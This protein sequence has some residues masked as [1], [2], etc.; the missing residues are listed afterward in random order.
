MSNGYKHENAFLYIGGGLILM[1]VYGWT[2]NILRFTDILSAAFAAY[3]A[4]CLTTAMSR[5]EKRK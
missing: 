3:V 5:A 1:A 4:L 2:A